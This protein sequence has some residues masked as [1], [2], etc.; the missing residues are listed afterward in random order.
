MKFYY[1]CIV[2]AN[3]DGLSKRDVTGGKI[4]FPIEKAFL[5]SCRGS[6]M[7]GRAEH[8]YHPSLNAQHPYKDDYSLLLAAPDI[9]R[10]YISGGTIHLW[11]VQVTNAEYIVRLARYTWH[12]EE[13][14]GGKVARRREEKEEEEEVRRS[15]LMHRASRIHQRRRKFRNRAIIN[16][17]DI[18][19]A[20]LYVCK[21]Y[22]CDEMRRQA[23]EY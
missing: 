15:P 11:T 5:L 22:G 8:C 18:T 9:S 23:T 21:V 17:R 3:F 4:R 12:R 19:D 10:I 16:A 14:R 20:S 1:R 13:W 6:A 2:N 7:S